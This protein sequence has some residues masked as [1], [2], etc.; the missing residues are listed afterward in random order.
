M[1]LLDKKDVGN[2]VLFIFKF[3]K[4]RKPK[5]AGTTREGHAFFTCAAFE[6]SLA[7]LLVFAKRG[8]EQRHEQFDGA[9]AKQV[10]S[11][12]Q[13]ECCCWQSGRHRC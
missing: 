13:S 7:H 6:G 1:H 8:G 12:L 10:L 4:L 3:C 5:R 11:R 2:Y 9:K